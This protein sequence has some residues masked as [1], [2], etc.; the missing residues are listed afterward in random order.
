MKWFHE[1]RKQQQQQ[2]DVELAIKRPL[3]KLYY[4]RRRARAIRLEV[5]RNFQ[6]R[7]LYIPVSQ[8][9]KKPLKQLVENYYYKLARGVK[10]KRN[11]RKLAK[12]L[13]GRIKLRLI[14]ETPKKNIKRTVSD[15]DSYVREKNF[16]E[17]W[18]VELPLK[19][20]TNKIYNKNLLF[21]NYFPEVEVVVKATGVD[22]LKKKLEVERQYLMEPAYA[23]HKR[24][25][26]LGKPA[27][28]I[29][30][31]AELEFDPDAEDERRLKVSVDEQGNKHFVRVKEQRRQYEHVADFD[32]ELLPRPE[33]FRE[34]AEELAFEDSRYEGDVD[35]AEQD[36]KDYYYSRPAVV[37]F[38]SDFYDKNKHK[39]KNPCTFNKYME[40]IKKFNVPPVEELPAVDE[41]LSKYFE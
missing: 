6:Y 28:K 27:P 31:T 29:T 39:E 14:L 25:K 22:D 2:S 20:R 30:I 21:Y 8:W 11:R 9:S 36:I 37:K 10:S 15:I 35:K 17:N 13:S 23:L 7:E 38:L 19:R 40:N 32:E 16:A 33:T 34:W 3:H 41:V 26:M 4:S 5:R 24:A 1:L 18:K 12:E